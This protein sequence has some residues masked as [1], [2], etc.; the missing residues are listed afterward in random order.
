MAIFVRAVSEADYQAW[1]VAQRK[2]AAD[3]ASEVQQRGRDVFLRATCPQCH[4]IRGT[5][6]GGAFGPDLT[7]IGS[8][9]TIAAG[10]LPNT[11]DNLQRWIRNPQQFK[12][13]NKMPPHDLNDGD[14]QAV[15]DYLRSLK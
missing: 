8:R 10:V 2:P 9:A 6:A 4:A 13:G 1:L 7:H 11:A 12:P 15:A 14:L 3:P 5:L